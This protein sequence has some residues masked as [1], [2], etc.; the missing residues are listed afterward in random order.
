MNKAGDYSDRCVWQTRTIGKD[1]TGQDV[2]SFPDGGFLWCS[3]E[4]ETGRR[5]DDYGT[6]QTGENG[7][8]RIRN[9]P[10]VSALDRLYRPEWDETWILDTVVYG[11]D[12]TICAA[13]TFE[14]LEV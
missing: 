10:G 9:Y 14:A 6:P 11:D 12:E 5:Q 13:H 4:P 7:T 2:E 1:A 8:I 3:V